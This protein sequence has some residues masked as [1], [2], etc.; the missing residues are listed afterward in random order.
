M[1]LKRSIHFWSEIYEDSCKKYAQS[2]QK[3]F[4]KS[5]KAVLTQGLKKPIAINNGVPSIEFKLNKTTGKYESIRLRKRKNMEIE[6]EMQN[7]NERI[8]QIEKETDYKP[9]LKR[10]KENIP[11][12]ASVGAAIAIKLSKQN[13]A[14]DFHKR[15]KKSEIFVD[16]LGQSP[17]EVFEEEIQKPQRVKSPPFRNLIFEEDKHCNRSTDTDSGMGDIKL[18]G[19]KNTKEQCSQTSGAKQSKTLFKADMSCQTSPLRFKSFIGIG[20][21][22]QKSYEEMKEERL[23]RQTSSSN[24]ISQRISTDPSQDKSNK[25]IHTDHTQLSQQSGEINQEE[26][27]QK[28]PIILEQ[29]IKI[30][31]IAEQLLKFENIGTQ[32]SN[33]TITS[34]VENLNN[35]QDSLPTTLNLDVKTEPAVT[36][37]LFSPQKIDINRL[38]TTVRNSEQSTEDKKSMKNIKLNDSTNLESNKLIFDFLKPYETKE[39]SLVTKMQE[40]NPFLLSNSFGSPRDDLKNTSNETNPFL[41]T[42]NAPIGIIGLIERH[43]SDKKSIKS[44]EGGLKP[45]ANIEIFENQSTQHFSTNNFAE[46]NNNIS[47]QNPNK[48]LFSNINIGKSNSVNVPM[49]NFGNSKMSV[50]NNLFGN[51]NNNNNSNYDPSIKS[52]NIFANKSSNKDAME[53]ITEIKPSMNNINNGSNL[54]GPNVSQNNNM[55]SLFLQKSNI[56]VQDNSLFSKNILNI[57]SQSNMNNTNNNLKLQNESNNS[58]SG[59]LFGGINTNNSTNNNLFS[60][61]NLN[62]N[63]LFN[64]QQSSNNLFATGKNNTNLLPTQLNFNNQPIGNFNQN[65]IGLFNNNSMETFDISNKLSFSNN[66]NHSFFE[67][68]PSEMQNI[69]LFNSNNHFIS[70]QFSGS[71]LGSNFNNAPLNKERAIEDANNFLG[72]GN[73]NSNSNM[74]NSANASNGT[75]T[76]QQNRVFRRIIQPTNRNRERAFHG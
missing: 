75:D 56:N 41:A 27:Q 50:T 2:T 72:L 38:P 7:I 67:N 31:T 68:K 65:Q 11:R 5:L 23:S 52:T 58:F 69:N 39:S 37:P 45:V 16:K 13:Q 34:T 6:P 20:S 33:E 59:N 76:N 44:L 60:N 54:F 9:T 40:N 61:S 3:S 51:I 29:E 12:R 10:M 62:S 32:K 49:N 42:Q 47:T 35:Q 64:N 63:L 15:K 46:N 66:N 19:L 74:N 53:D 55:N 28:P 73:N 71:A 48:G 14:N 1:N 18:I 57:T 22:S 17:K 36:K 43:S 24:Q 30:E 26:T 25:E 8:S 70:Q 21:N 4:T